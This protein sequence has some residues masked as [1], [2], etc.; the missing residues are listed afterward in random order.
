[1]QSKGIE[2]PL[3]HDDITRFCGTG[4]VQIEERERLSEAFREAVLGNG[5]VRRST[6]VRDQLAVFVVNRNHN[7]SAEKSAATIQT[8]AKC[9]N[10]GPR[11]PACREVR[12]RG[13]DVLQ[14]KPQRRVRFGTRV[15]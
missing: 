5:V 4:A 6:N 14:G 3:D 1:M 13:I 2:K 10:R 8:D 7:P 11:Q 12:M 9:T 15:R